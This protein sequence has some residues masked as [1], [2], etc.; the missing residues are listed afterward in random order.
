MKR[1]TAVLL[2]LVF[3]AGL[4]AGGQVVAKGW[5]PGLASSSSADQNISEN[6]RLASST[7]EAV[8]IGPLNIADMVARV[9]P[10]VVHIE[11]FIKVDSGMDPF[12]N[13]PFFR[14]FF[15]DTIKPE[16]QY[17]KGIGTGFIITDSGYILT[18]YH[19]VRGANQINVRLTGYEQP[20]KAKVIGFDEQLDL[21]VIKI[22]VDRKLPTIPLGNSDTTRVGEWVVAIGNPY[23]L[24]H[25]V[26][27]GVISAKER[28]ITIEGRRYK[29]LIQTDAAINPGNSG[30]PLINIQGQVVGINTAVNAQAQGIG[31]AIPINT[32]KDVLDQLI[33]KGK[34]VRPYMGVYLQDL[35]EE[36]AGFLGASSTNGAV[37][38]GVMPDSPAAKANL[39]KG[40]IILAVN[41]KAVENSEE[42]TQI[43]GDL[44]VGDKITLEILRERKKISVSLVLEEKP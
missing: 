4:V 34:V 20:L 41:G 12:F 10:A 42:L 39:R 2:L 31:F 33:K 8:D 3:L 18:N 13:D 43:I 9:S 25:T 26:T 24:D 6:Y 32:A 5:V 11:A 36:L 35:T 19:V 37:V 30:G 17:E 7:N 1:S 29:N 14:E 27:V 28:P 15:G 40:D 16:P 44:K 21:A 23:G 22:T 38:A